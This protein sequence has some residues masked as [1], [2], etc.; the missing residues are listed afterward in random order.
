[1]GFRG[2]FDSPFLRR[3]AWH[4]KRIADKM[5]R[6]FFTSLFIILGI[7][8]AIA[9]AIV[10]L[11]ETDRTLGDFGAS[12]YWAI[13]TVL[14]QGD[15]SYVSGPAGWAVGWFLG[16]FGVT[17]VATITGA[18]VGFVIDFLLKE[19]QGMGASGYRDHVIICGWNSTA[20]DLIAELSTDDYETKLVL[21][22]DMERSP[23]SDGVYFVRGNPSTEA[24]LRRAGVE[25]A[26]SAI[27]CPADGTNEADMASILT[28][29]AIESIAPRV[30]TIVEVNNPEHVAHFRRANVDEV[31]VT[32]RL[33]SHLLARS[34]L[35]PG[36]S[37]L[38]TD[39]VS[40]GEGDELYRVELPDDC[41][42]RPIDDVSAMLR[43][44]HNATLLAVT[45]DDHTYTNP[46]TDFMFEVGDDLIVVAESLGAL[47]P[48]EH[49]TAYDDL[50]EE[51]ELSPKEVSV[52]D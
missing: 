48:L 14:G 6:R 40:G 39:L 47:S 12:F 15:A 46:K 45:R 22:A 4:V 11:T 27:V 29:L 37:E 33:A 34:A 30:R 50:E 36:L 8:L 51:L 32:S 19:G 13:T 43:R 24:D 31:M 38:V 42:G 10:W 28:V 49:S 1:M 16:L 44:E 5:D 7:V 52:T 2:M 17:I 41:V 35:Y 25:N 18:L 26:I 9:A 21:L 3:V 20:R 23:A